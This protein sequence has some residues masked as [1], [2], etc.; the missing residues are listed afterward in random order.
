MKGEKKLIALVAHDEKKRELL[1]WVKY[2]AQILKEHSLITTATTGRLIK[3]AT[4]LNCALCKS[5][6][7]GGDSELGAKIAAGDIDM[8]IFFWDGLSV[9]A[10]KPDI[11][12]LLRLA[13]I[14]NIPTACNK[15]TADMIISSSLFHDSTYKPE[16]PDFDNY[17]NRSIV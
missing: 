1:D 15:A 5:G 10:H 7:L 12:S 17:I 16:K 6:P 9:H 4:D 2:N 13:V 3:T 8:L 14:Y 11:E